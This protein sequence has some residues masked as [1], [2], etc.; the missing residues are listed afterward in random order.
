MASVEFYGT[1][2]GNERGGGRRVEEHRSTAFI[3]RERRDDDH[4]RCFA[5]S[6]WLGQ[7]GCEER[8]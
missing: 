5:V 1:E 8:A 7:R 2:C 4:I 3:R 6:S